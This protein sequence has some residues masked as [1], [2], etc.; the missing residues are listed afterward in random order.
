MDSITLRK[1]DDFHLH[2][3]RGAM[4]QNV[5]PS[6][7]RQ[8]ARGLIMPN[9]LPKP[10]LTW[11]DANEYRKEILEA[12]K[13]AE[14]IHFEPLTTIQ[15]TDVTT[16]AMIVAAREHNIVAGKA[17]PKG[18][19]TNSHNGISDFRRLTPVL[20]QM[21]KEGLVL[22]IHGQQPGV[23]CLDRE[24]EFIDTLQWIVKTFRKLRVVVEH[25]ST[26]VMVNAVKHMPPRVAATVTLHHLLLTL[27]DILCYNDGIKEGLNPHHYCQPIPQRPEDRNALV[28]VVVRVGNPKFFF[29]SDSAPHDQAKKEACCGAA[30]VFSA[31]VLL[32]ALVQLFDELGALNRLEA[33]VSEFGAK[34]YGLEVNKSKITL[35]RKDWVVPVNIGSVVPLFAGQTLPWKVV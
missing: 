16:S 30:G 26:A 32:P 33:F 22:C 2:L 25:V 31:P 27:D 29:G 14:G 3:R 19:T 20:M 8:F 17:Y 12:T 13:K 4:M 6:S 34:F 10:I 15:L 23:F 21:Q 35:V 7:M 18:V 11:D 24:K 28:E 1:P 9:T 5:L